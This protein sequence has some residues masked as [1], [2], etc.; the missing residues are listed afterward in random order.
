MSRYEVWEDD[1]TL[2][3][4]HM[5][6]CPEPMELPPGYVWAEAWSA[7]DEFDL[8]ENDSE[9]VKQMERAA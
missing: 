7:G 9:L 6:T 2:Y 3:D 4:P 5:Y 1:G 8:T